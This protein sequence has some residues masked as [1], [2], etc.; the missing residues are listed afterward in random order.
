EGSRPEDGAYL[1]DLAAG[2]KEPLTARLFAWLVGSG[3]TVVDGGAYLGFY[4]LLAA[5]RVGRFGEVLAF[6]PNPQ[7]FVLLER[8][9]RKNG[10]ERRVIARRGC[11]AD[12]PGRRRFHLSD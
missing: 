6:E 10:Y 1:I 4:M 8:N 7:T 3:D 9:V 12:R 5:R 11:I 2:H